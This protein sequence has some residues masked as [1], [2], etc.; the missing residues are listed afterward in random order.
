MLLNSRSPQSPRHSSNTLHSLAT[1]SQFRAFLLRP[2]DGCLDF[3]KR[4]SCRNQI[5]FEGLEMGEEGE[6]LDGACDGVSERVRYCVR[7]RR[8]R[9]GGLAAANFGVRKH[10]ERI[11]DP[12]ISRLC[13][14][15]IARR[16]ACRSARSPVNSVRSSFA[17]RSSIYS[18]EILSLL[19][20]TAACEFVTSVSRSF[21]NC[22]GPRLIVMSR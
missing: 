1:S 21:V 20:D 17:K 9:D 3:R 10:A 14:C 2:S 5:E 19:T 12:P 13:R 11:G 15:F 18:F 8:R 22:V 7:T 6:I 4:C 16:A